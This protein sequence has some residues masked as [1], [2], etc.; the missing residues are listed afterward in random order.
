M[1]TITDYQTGVTTCYDDEG[2][3][4]IPEEVI[5]EEKIDD[6]IIALKEGKNIPEFVKCLDGLACSDIFIS[7]TLLSELGAEYL[8]EHITDEI[9][10]SEL[11]KAQDKE[12]N[13]MSPFEIFDK[14]GYDDGMEILKENF[15]KEFLCEC[16]FTVFEM[17]ERNKK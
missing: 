14:F 9:L 16:L 13:G 11:A 17:Y 12:I 1:K 3:R 10:E 5:L 7:R 2:N 8:A 6:A 4:I 15:S